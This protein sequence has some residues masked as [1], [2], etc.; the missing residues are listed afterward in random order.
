MD[1]FI[2]EPINGDGWIIQY[3]LDAAQKGPAVEMVVDTLIM[4]M[5]AGYSASELLR[6]WEFEDGRPGIKWIWPTN[7]AGQRIWERFLRPDVPN[8]GRNRPA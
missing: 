5:R 3:T 1:F 8:G 4:S 7:E 6:E 2:N